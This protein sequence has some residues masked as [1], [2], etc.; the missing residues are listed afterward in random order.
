[1]AYGT[2]DRNNGDTFREQDV[3]QFQANDDYLRDEADYKIIANIACGTTTTASTGSYSISCDDALINTIGTQSDT[4]VPVTGA[5]G[6]RTASIIGQTIRWICTEDINYISMF[7]NVSRV[8][9]GNS[10]IYTINSITII[11]HRTVETW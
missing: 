1:M 8:T 9:E 5:T 4:N 2:V 3:D 6:V 10:Y 11:G 7:A